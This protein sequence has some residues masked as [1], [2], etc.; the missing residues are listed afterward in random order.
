MLKRIDAKYK[1]RILA[2]AVVSLAILLLFLVRALFPNRQY[3]CE[4]DGLF[5]P[6]VEGG[7]ILGESI[8]L[9]MGVYRVEVLYLTDKDG[10]GLVNLSGPDSSHMVSNGEVFYKNRGYTDFTVWLYEKTDNLQLLVTGSDDAYIYIDSF[11]IYETDRLW[12]MAMCIVV[13][14]SLSIIALLSILGYDAKCGIRKDNKVIIIGLLAIVLVSSLP[15]LT[16]KLYSGAD[17]GYHIARI[18]GVKWSIRSK[19]FP[20]RIEPSMLFNRGYADAVFYCD[21]FLYI[22]A[23]FRLIGFDI[24]AA[25]NIFSVLW[26]AIA[27]VISYCSFKGIFRD[28]Y[29]GLMCAALYMTAGVRTYMIMGGVLGQLCASAFMPIL[30]LA[31][32]RLLSENYETPEYKNIWLLFVAGYS[33]IIQS[34]VLSCEITLLWTFAVCLLGIRKILRKETILE[35]LK[36][37]CGTLLLN[38][39][40]LVPFVDYYI[41]EDIAIKHYGARTIQD[42]GIDLRQLLLIHG[43]QAESY[44]FTGM[45]LFFVLALVMCFLVGLVALKKG[46]KTPELGLA[47]ICA[48]FGV[49][50]SL[51]A[52]K[53]FPWDK[54]HDIPFLA[55]L[56]GNIQFPY[57]FLVWGTA[58][59]VIVFGFFAWYSKNV[60]KSRLMQYVVWGFIAVTIGVSHLTYI[61]YEINNGYTTQLYDET[62][63]PGY[64][65]GGEYVVHGTDISSIS[66]GIVEAG[67]NTILESASTGYLSGTA[68]VIND[69]ETDSYVDFPLTHYKGYKAEDSFGNQLEC[70]KGRNNVVRVVLPKGYSGSVSVRFVSPVLWRLC[71]I[72]SLAFDIFIVIYLLKRRKCLNEDCCS[73]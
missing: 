19:I 8:S 2:V 4:V 40:F 43:K 66:Y 56:V 72:V 59:T 47:I 28:K 3:H 70:T 25:Y 6:N 38:L 69:G 57:R 17:L 71:E 46:D 67:E 45:G 26:T 73:F 50:S 62:M 61:S 54:V 51:F 20:V 7:N 18:E 12:G 65:S 68:T 5:S 42:R 55:S 31:Y 9:P 53:N 14:V 30:I 64:I 11:N 37:A 39:W 27:T 33:G 34:H 63:Q 15:F 49:L 13:S 23:F 16:G 60:R 32:Y 36:G 24:I 22:P 29:I 35:L 58:F 21:A 41:N 48:I 44:E 1:K 52:L 10:S